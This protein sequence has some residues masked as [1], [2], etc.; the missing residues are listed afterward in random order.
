MGHIFNRFRDIATT[1]SEIAD[2]NHPSHLGPIA[3]TIVSGA[4]NTLE[5]VP[6]PLLPLLPPLPFL[7][8]SLPLE[9]GP[10]IAGKGSGGAL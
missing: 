4:S 1:T 5:Q 6:P 10:L 9:V 3:P 7:S 2:F 8:F